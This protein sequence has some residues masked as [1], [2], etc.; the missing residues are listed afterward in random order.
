VTELLTAAQ[1]REI[2]Q[3]AIESGK[4]TGLELM[5]RAGQ[6]VVDAILE[7]W[8][9]LEQAPHRAVVLC[10]PGNNGGDGFVVARLL[11]ARGWSVEVFLFGVATNLPADAHKNYLRWLDIGTVESLDKPHPKTEQIDEFQHA[12]SHTRDIQNDIDLEPKPAFLVID[13]LFGIGLSRPIIGLDNLFVHWDYLSTFRD[14]NNSRL[15][16]IDVP[17]G[18]NADKGKPVS[19]KLTFPVLCSD[20]TVTFH[21]PKPVHTSPSAASYCGKVVVKDIGL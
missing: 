5:E 17:S 6:G 9:E 16:A 7:E 2:E 8:P 4:V 13:A 20:L 15:V 3:S 10:G 11:L 19:D 1:M 21:K 14:L 12:A 18:L